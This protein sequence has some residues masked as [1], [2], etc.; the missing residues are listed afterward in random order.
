MIVQFFRKNYNRTTSVLTR[1]FLPNLCCG[2]PIIKINMQP[3]GAFVNGITQ[4]LYALSQRDKTSEMA[5]LDI[6]STANTTINQ[7]ATINLTYA[8]IP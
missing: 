1:F 8:D 2:T 6:K 7:T 5:A 4:K 3:A